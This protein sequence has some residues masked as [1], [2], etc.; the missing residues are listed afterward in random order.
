MTLSLQSRSE[1]EFFVESL[2]RAADAFRYHGVRLRAYS[3]G[4]A[5]AVLGAIDP[6][7]EELEV[8]IASLRQQL[9][10]GD[11]QEMIV[12]EQR[13]LIFLAA[14]T[15]VL[16]DELRT[17][18]SERL[19]V[20]NDFW[21]PISLAAQRVAVQDA[22]HTLQHAEYLATKLGPLHEEMC[23][24][25]DHGRALY[26]R[27]TILYGHESGGLVSFRP[28]SGSLFASILG[29]LVNEAESPCDLEWL[30]DHRFSASTGEDL[31]ASQEPP[32]KS[33]AAWLRRYSARG[34]CL[35]PIH[36][37][38]AGCV[39]LNVVALP[40]PAPNHRAARY[41]RE[42]LRGTDVRSRKRQRPQ[43][44]CQ[45]KGWVARDSRPRFLRKRR[46]TK[47]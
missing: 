29:S 19:A 25:G 5:L 12:E 27:S 17:L 23:S 37:A 30:E 9:E 26:P 28:K 39:E 10:A 4:L 1:A 36:G 15:P 20:F 14:L 22:A 16:Y 35:E 13:T 32:A 46:N 2:E 33:V 8:F 47:H 38:F 42:K 43:A 24:L 3:D 41:F 11:D 44:C 7:R 45:P 21:R 6:I 34:V 31:L 40:P 18:A